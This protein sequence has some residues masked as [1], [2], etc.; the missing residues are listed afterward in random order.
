MKGKKITNLPQNTWGKIE[1]ILQRAIYKGNSRSSYSYEIYKKQRT[2]E[3][4]TALWTP[5]N[6]HGCAAWPEKTRLK[7]GLGVGENLGGG[8]LFFPSQ[9]GAHN[10]GYRIEEG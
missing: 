10:L 5:P 8:A 6:C 4:L 1:I 2:L 3:N 9:I 7:K